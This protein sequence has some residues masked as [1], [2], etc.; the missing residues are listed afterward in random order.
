[1]IWTISVWLNRQ[2]KRQRLA[3][4]VLPSALHK[5][6]GGPLLGAEVWGPTS[7][8]KTTAEMRWTAQSWEGGP[9][10]NLTFTLVPVT[11]SGTEA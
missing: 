3:A 6:C 9:M 8:D 1:M 10:G 5:S 11:V 7:R 4:A 2:I